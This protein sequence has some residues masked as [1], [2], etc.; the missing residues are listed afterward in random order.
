MTPQTNQYC[1]SR[2]GG[3]PYFVSNDAVSWVAACAG[4]I[5]FEFA[6][7]NCA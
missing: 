6:F 4:T 1:H 5:R 3:N 2:E 7:A